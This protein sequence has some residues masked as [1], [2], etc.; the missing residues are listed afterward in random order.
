MRGGGTEPERGGAPVNNLDRERTELSHGGRRR[1]SRGAL[2]DLLLPSRLVGRLGARGGPDAD[3]GGG[4][5]GD[6]VREA[7]ANS[8]GCQ[9]SL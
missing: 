1:R 4:S 2:E 6:T 7:A 8:P 3:G 5:R 9:S